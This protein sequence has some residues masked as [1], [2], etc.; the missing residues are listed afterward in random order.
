[1]AHIRSQLC[2]QFQAWCK[3][4]VFA[5][6]V[7]VASL[8]Q[9]GFADRWFRKPASAHEIGLLPFPMKDALLP[10]ETLQ[11]HLST[12]ASMA[13]LEK[14]S[15]RD[16]GVLGQLVEQDEGKTVC[17]VTP[18]L[19]LREH[20]PHPTVGVWCSF[21]CVG[22]V[23]ISDVE[24]RTAEEEMSLGRVMPGKSPG[25]QFL[26]AQARASRSAPRRTDPRA[27]RRHAHWQVSRH[28]VLQQS[29][30]RRV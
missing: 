14:A 8:V 10:G 16:H 26:V 2:S 20:R 29:L 13:L 18:V 1:M 21:T 3:M 5:L 30:G 7:M 17:A 15:T 12:D 24:L 25:A 4:F 11:I 19:E 27:D 6:G 28:G 9:Q 22:S 23:S